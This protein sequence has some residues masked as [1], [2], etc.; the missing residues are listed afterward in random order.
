MIFLFFISF[1]CPQ[2]FSA[3]LRYRRSGVPACK[4]QVLQLPLAI[5]Q[6]TQHEVEYLVWYRGRIQPVSL[7]GAISVMFGI[8][9]SLRVH[10]CKRHE[11]IFTT[12]LW[13]NNGRQNVLIIS[14]M[15]FSQLYEIMVHKVT[16]VGFRGM[17]APIAPPGSAFGLMKKF[18]VSF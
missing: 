8:Q 16:F 5:E 11:V 1:H 15:L 14:R 9:V 3:P 10:Y 7:G 18:K 12:R 4:A 17:V 13:Q 2:L 6:D